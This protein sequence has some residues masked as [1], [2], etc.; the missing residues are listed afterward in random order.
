MEIETENKFKLNKP[1]IFIK[2]DKLYHDTN[3]TC[4]ICNKTCINKVRD[5]CHETDNYRGPAC[6]IC[7]L[8]YRKQN[9][10]PVVF[11]NGKGYDF[12]QIFSETFTQNNNNRRVDALPGTNGKAR[13]FRVGTKVYR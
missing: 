3:N 10:I 13:M 8:N 6:N 9:F 12:N 2:E 4:H 1:I 11:H 5:H 7:N